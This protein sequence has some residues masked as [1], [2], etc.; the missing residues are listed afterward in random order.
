M[1]SVIVA[2]QGHTSLWRDILHNWTSE[3]RSVIVSLQSHTR[4]WRVLYC[5]MGTSEIRR[6]CCNA[7]SHKPMDGSYCTIGHPKSD[8]WL[9]H[10]KVTDAY[11]GSYYYNGTSEI[12]NRTSEIRSVIFYTTRS[13]KLCDL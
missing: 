8:M 10:C 9:F 3:I 12:Q 1:R 7:R 4:L 2:M 13:H 5:T 11:G 6:D